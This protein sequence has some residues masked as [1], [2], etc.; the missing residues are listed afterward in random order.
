MRPRISFIITII[1][2]TGWLCGA[3]VAKGGGDWIELFDGTSLTGWVQR[4]GEA[5]YAVEDG[6]IVG[7]TVPRTPNSFLCTEKMY[8]DFVLELEFK[9]DSALN[10]G[11][12]IRSNSLPGYKDGRVH[13]YQVEIDPSDRAWSG[14]IY[15]EGRRGWLNDLRGNKAARSAFRPNDWNQYRV[16]AIGDSI[17]TWINGTPAADL[18]DSMTS[19]GFIAL[20]VHGV[21]KREEALQVRWRN[22]RIQDYGVSHWAPLYNGRDF[23]GWVVPETGAW[24]I[25][26]GV[27]HGVSS[28]DQKRHSILLSDR[29]YR[30]FTVRLVYR[31]LA[32][33]SGFYFRVE[34]RE[35]NTM[36][37][38]YQAEIDATG[39][40]VA[41][42]YETGGRKWLTQP[43][44]ELTRE[45]FGMADWNEMTVSAHGERLAV[46]LNGKRMA[47]IR[48]AAGRRQGLLGLQLHGG[49]VMD[50]EFK[51]VEL[52]KTSAK[53]PMQEGS[54]GKAAAALPPVVPD[55]AEVIKLADGFKFTEGPAR[56]IDGRIYFSDIP[57]ERIHVH[58]PASGMTEV[59]RE[60]TGRANGLMWTPP[61]ALIACEGGNRRLSRQAGN[62]VVTLA[63][64]YKGKKLNSPNDL[65]LDGTGGVY[66]TDPRYGSEEGREME[67]MGV[68]YL[69][70]R[71]ELARVVE[72]LAKPNGLIF[73][74]DETIL[75]I[76][77]PGAET[78]WAYDVVDPGGLTNKRKF[79]GV[80][81]DGMTVDARGNV[82]C[83]FEG[84]VWIFS[85][86]GEEVGRIT[87]PEKP[88]NV[89][90]GGP[91]GKTLYITARKGFYSVELN[92]KGG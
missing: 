89:T 68:Y 86:Q 60:N 17:K 55:G 63:D 85:P 50:V 26:E 41:G 44:P 91:D 36:V 52:L 71:G 88:S 72:D 48:D 84:D 81:S 4:G 54:A 22:I 29:E 65:V 1:F 77:D 80:G 69:P 56:G 70:R 33:N 18:V 20:Q 82:Y 16:V 3:A 24:K 76:A 42:I 19:R 51:S 53:R 15:D 9:V 38:G 21:G 78:I 10:S 46:H 37:F 45:V 59:F 28:R 23:D 27:L 66:F 57:N 11:V 35:E 39:K 75:Y 87:P 62:E 13:G 5:K 49:Q 64:S 25:E 34:P 43:A 2:S 47:D 83:T 61:G 14:G 74:P 92:V 12:Q 73:S 40:N 6:V 90:F 32:G 8:G 58:D 79:A 30:D 31:C 67:V 7:S